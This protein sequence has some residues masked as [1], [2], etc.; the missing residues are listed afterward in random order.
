M[1]ILHGIF[2]KKSS[3]RPDDSGNSRLIIFYFTHTKEKVCYNKRY[4]I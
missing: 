1:R 4:Y 3:P 2:S